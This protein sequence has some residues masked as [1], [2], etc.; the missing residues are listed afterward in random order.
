[1]YLDAILEV[2][3]G[4]V[5]T[6]LVL[7]IATMQVQEWISSGLQLRAKFL[8]ESIENMLQGENLV[9]EFYNHPMIASLSSPGRKPSYIP[10]ERFAQTVDE[11]YIQKSEKIKKELI[12]GKKLHLE[13]VN[14]I[15]RVSARRLRRKGYDTVEK[16][17]T[18]EEKELRDIFQLIRYANLADEKAILQN[19]KDLLEEQKQL[20][21]KQAKRSQKTEE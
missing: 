9:D 17:A 14:G 15:G 11:V 12:Y 13:D 3:I 4:M 18:M 21:K 5:F 7:S 10:A 8:K 20:Q 19:A 16:L 2:A 1:M 6:W